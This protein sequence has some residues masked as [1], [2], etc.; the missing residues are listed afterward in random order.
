MWEREETLPE[1]IEKAWN[2]GAPIQHLG[3]IASTLGRAKVS[4]RSWSQKKFGAV[5]RELKCIRQRIEE[6]ESQSSIADQCKLNTLRHH[7]DELLYRK[8]MMW[9]Q[10]SRIAWLKE[11]D[12]NTKYFHNNA[13]KER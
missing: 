8:E 9:L 13:P 7:M 3:D 10:C 4:L 6:I 12:R 2:A 11:G 5:T 1:E